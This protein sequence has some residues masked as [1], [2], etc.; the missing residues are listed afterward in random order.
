MLSDL[1]SRISCSRPLPP[2]KLQRT[3]LSRPPSPGDLGRPGETRC[4]LVPMATHA[5][6]VDAC[7]GG[8]MK[9][10]SG[11]VVLVGGLGVWLA[12]LPW[13]PE[14]EAHSFVRQDGWRL[15]DARPTYRET[16]SFNTLIAQS[17]RPM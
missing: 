6:H 17:T 9:V 10:D 14:L 11:L 7:G 16:V 12:G 5:A 8:G 2:D 15:L 1:T 13:G 3:P 4:S